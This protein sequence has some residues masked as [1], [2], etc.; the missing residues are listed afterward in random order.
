MS[1]RPGPARAPRSFPPALPRRYSRVASGTSVAAAASMR[2]NSRGRGVAA[3]ASIV[4]PP[5][6]VARPG[7]AAALP[8]QASP[9]PTSPAAAAASLRPFVTAWGLPVHWL[10]GSR[11]PRLPAVCELPSGTQP[12]TPPTG[13]LGCQSGAAGSG[14]LATPP[15]SPGAEETDPCPSRSRWE[16]KAGWGQGLA[17]L[18]QPYLQPQRAR[19]RRWVCLGVSRFRK[20]A[21]AARSSIL[22]A[23]FLL[24]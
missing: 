6:P 19:A 3:A 21:V 12:E 23:F 7:P 8:Q 11:R 4:P 5:L 22:L 24:I 9:R 1:Q 20:K 18:A 16:L 13:P 17:S 2:R 14:L 15:D 10:Q